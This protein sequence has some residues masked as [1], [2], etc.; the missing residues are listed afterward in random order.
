MKLSIII[1]TL[2]EEAGIGNVLAEATK[3]ADEVIIVDGFSTDKT[4]EIAKKFPN[5]RV[6]QIPGKLGVALKYGFEQA[7]G[8]I[9]VIMD[10]DGSHRVSEVP[11]AV[12][13]IEDGAEVC[14]PSRFMP[15]GGSVD[16]PPVRVF[17]NWVFVK[18]VNLLYGSKYTDLNYGFRAFKKE[19][20]PAVNIRCTG[21][22]VITEM[23]IHAAKKKLK[24]V[25]VPSFEEARVGGVGKLHTVRD[26][27]RVLKLI[28][29]ERFIK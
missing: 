1:P 9:V 8:D 5:V 18:M 28:L 23:S 17:G 29:K 10:A 4:V 16:M 13:A 14:M 22:E 7:K 11:Q 15:G 12:K 3:L 24:V 27:W 21:F 6:F 26:G 20:I 25:E 2:N 19:I